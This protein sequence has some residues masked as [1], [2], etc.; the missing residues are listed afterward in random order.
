MNRLDRFRHDPGEIIG[1][2][3]YGGPNER[4][5]RLRRIPVRLKVDLDEDVAARMWP[6]QR[7]ADLLAT[8][9]RKALREAGYPMYSYGVDGWNVHPASNG[10]D[11]LIAESVEVDEGAITMLVSE[12]LRDKMRQLVRNAVHRQVRDLNKDLKVIRNAFGIDYL[13]SVYR[14]G[15]SVRPAPRLRRRS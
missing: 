11:L 2:D 6:G 5:D 13:V 12:T 15:G 3:D 4:A 8:A 9:V 7:L 1:P 10:V 14:V